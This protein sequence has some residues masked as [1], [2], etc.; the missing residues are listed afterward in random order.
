MTTIKVKP[1]QRTVQAPIQKFVNDFF[2]SSLTDLV[3]REFVYTR[4]AVNVLEKEDAFELFVAAPGLSKD[5]FSIEVENDVLMIRAEKPESD[6]AEDINYKRREFD[7]SGFKRTFK[8]HP[9][10]DGGKITAKYDS[11]IL[12]IVIPKVEKQIKQIEIQ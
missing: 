7:Y 2:N 12:T 6:A 4:P 8:L 3:D 9:M 1:Q 5:Q 11:G 10:L